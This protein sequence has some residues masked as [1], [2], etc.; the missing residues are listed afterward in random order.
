MDDSSAQ[1]GEES[2]FK[3]KKGKMLR[4]P[5]LDSAR[6]A[7]FSLFFNSSKTPPHLIHGDRETRPSRVRANRARVNS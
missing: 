3:Q 5:V 7:F 6:S 1:I 4:V 2:F